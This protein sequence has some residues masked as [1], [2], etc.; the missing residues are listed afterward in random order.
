MNRASSARGTSRAC[1]SAWIVPSRTR[2]LSGFDRQI[3]GGQFHP[4]RSP[5]PQA[6]QGRGTRPTDR[7]GQTVIRM[8]GLRPVNVAW[9]VPT[10]LTDASLQIEL[11]RHLWLDMKLAGDIA[12]DRRA[13]FSRA[14]DARLIYGF[15]LEANICRVVDPRAVA[16]GS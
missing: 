10:N 13:T 7:E 11:V 14:E 12:V 6:R 9:K 2:A 15:F 1:I 3:T 4:S 8:R 16:T 5:R